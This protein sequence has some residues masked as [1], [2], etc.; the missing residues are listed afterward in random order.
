[1]VYIRK[2]V[3]LLINRNKLKTKKQSR[4]GG[5]VFV[6]PSKNHKQYELYKRG[7]GS[8]VEPLLPYYIVILSISLKNS[9]IF[10]RFSGSKM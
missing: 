1:M 5:T 3:K 7:K 9:P 8:C 6:S 2:F 10:S 4:R